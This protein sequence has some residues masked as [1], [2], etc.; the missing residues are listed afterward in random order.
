MRRRLTILITFLAGL[1][2]FLEFM[3]PPVIPTNAPEGKGFRFGRYD[4]EISIGFA[5]VG[6]MAFALGAVSILYAHGGNVLR[7]R[8]RWVIS[9]ALILSMLVS[10]AVG[11]LMWRARARS[12]AMSQ[13]LERLV[14]AQDIIL[15]SAAKPPIP[16]HMS[17]WPKEEIPAELQRPATIGE[18]MAA[19]AK[20]VSAVRVLRGKIVP[21]PSSGEDA[22]RGPS[23]QLLAALQDAES[24]ATAGLDKLRGNDETGA[25]GDLQRS[26]DGLRKAAGAQRK[27]GNARLKDSTASHAYDLMFDGLYTALGSAMFSLLAFY[28]ATAAYRAFRIQSKEAFLLMLAALLVMLGQIPIGVWLVDTFLGWV[29]LESLSITQVRLWVLRVVNTAAFRGIAL[30]SGIAGLSMAWRVWWSMESGALPEEAHEGDGND[31]GSAQGGTS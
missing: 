20:L 29:G 19:Q 24:A 2:F 22:R 15:S 21:A 30:G 7:Q 1:Y 23:E 17:E 16:A 10:A 31:A 3:L 18:R 14:A 11:G 26:L 28:I 25:A 6:V 27:L 5:A 12:T 8:R 4:E 13:E 9:A